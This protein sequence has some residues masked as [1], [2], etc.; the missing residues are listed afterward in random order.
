MFCCFLT[1]ANIVTGKVSLDLEQGSHVT[2][3][4]LFKNSVINIPVFVH[5]LTVEVLL[6]KDQRW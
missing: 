1:Q 2:F 5:S 3:F 6:T 4:I